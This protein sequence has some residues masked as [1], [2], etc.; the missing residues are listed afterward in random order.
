AALAGRAQAGRQF[1]DRAIPICRPSLRPY[2][3]VEGIGNVDRL[4]RDN[5]LRGPGTGIDAGLAYRVETA[6]SAAPFGQDPG[7]AGAAMRRADALAVVAPDRGFR[8]IAARYA[9]RDEYAGLQRVYA[10]RRGR[11]IRIGGRRGGNQ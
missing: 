1:A 10:A 11:V 9:L 5:A 4:L 3:E 2:C 7:D 8:R 6:I